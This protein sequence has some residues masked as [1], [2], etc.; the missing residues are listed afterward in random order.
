MLLHNPHAIIDDDIL[1][2]DNLVKAQSSLDI[3]ETAAIVLD[4]QPTCS[5]NL[6]L[7]TNNQELHPK[8]QAE[9]QVVEAHFGNAC[10]TTML[11]QGN[12]VPVVRRKSNKKKKKL[13]LLK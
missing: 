7:D 4:S 10:D 11:Q 5:I 12:F 9:L 13:N 2:T 1:H 6:A 3:S 8:M